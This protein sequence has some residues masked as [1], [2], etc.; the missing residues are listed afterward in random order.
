MPKRSTLTISGRT[1]EGLPVDG[2]DVI[3]WDRELAGFGSRGP[4]RA[5]K[6]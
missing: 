4:T 2:K 3:F 6:S 1:V 5:K